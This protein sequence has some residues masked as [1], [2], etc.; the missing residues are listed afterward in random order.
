MSNT[1]LVVDDE[2]DVITF[3]TAVLQES[4]YKTLSAKDGVEALE[5]LRKEKP[6]LVLLDLMMPKKSGITMFQELRKDPDTSHIAVV[7]VTGVS[8]VTG[9]DFRDFM[10]KQ[11]LRDE[12]KFVEATGLTKLTIPDGYVEKPIDP[13]ELVKVV[14]E[15]LNA[16]SP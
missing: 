2:P 6:D 15:A 3:L 9:V 10:Y 8:E 11:T 12:K 4:G 13:E 1:I 7:V 5:I 14:K 16:P